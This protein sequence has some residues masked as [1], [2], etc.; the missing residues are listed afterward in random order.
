MQ[1]RRAANVQLRKTSIKITTTK[2]RVTRILFLLI[3]LTLLTS[4]KE[5]R[6]LYIFNDNPSDESLSHG[7]FLE[8]RI[9]SNDSLTIYD[10]DVYARI[11][12]NEEAISIP[13]VLRIVSPSGQ[14][15]TDTLNLDLSKAASTG[16]FARS[17]IWKDF[18]WS[19]RRGVSLPERGTWY[20]RLELKKGSTEVPGMA[21]LGFILI[22]K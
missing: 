1:G 8:Y 3:S 13:A 7:E 16:M 12:T 17:G 11:H 22:K 14:K 18:R 20:L 19:Y 9:P 4:C 2:S 10:I 6:E 15:Y 21:E 5:R